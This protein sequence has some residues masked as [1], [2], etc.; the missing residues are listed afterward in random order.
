MVGVD[1]TATLTERKAAAFVDSRT[2]LEKLEQTAPGVVAA[3]RLLL[4]KAPH[5]VKEASPDWVSRSLDNRVHVLPR[6][7]ML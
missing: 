7:P 5:T 3:L 2:E 4:E 6:G 1:T